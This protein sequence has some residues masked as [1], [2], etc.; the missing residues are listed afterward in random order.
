VERNFIVVAL[1]MVGVTGAAPTVSGQAV[2]AQ[3]APAPP[4]ERPAPVISPE[5]GADGRVTF[6]FRGPN[7][8][9]VAV[10][11]E[12]VKD[13]LT[14]QKDEQGVWS[15]TSEPLAPDYYGYS[16][17]V[18]GVTMFDSTN[19]SVIPNFL[20]RASEVHVPASAARGSGAASLPWEL[21]D[22]PHGEIH[23][24]FYKSGVVGDERGF[25]VYTPPGYDPRGKQTYPVLYLLHGYSDDANAWTA[26]GRA[27][28]ILDNLI[29]QGKA[30]PMLVVM[31]LGYGAPEVLAPHSGVFH[32]PAITQRNFDRFREA[33]LTEVI[34]RVEENYLVIKERNARA[35]AGLSMGGAETL[36]TGLNNLD[37][38]A[39]IA[40]L[41]SGG[42]TKDFD[43]EF[44][45]LDAKAN[46]QLR[47][48]WIACGTDDHLIGINRELR[49]WLAAKG[50]KHVDIE[51]PG[52]H[53]WMVWRRNL[54][55]FLPLL[56]R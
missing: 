37:K 23:H 44:P 41:S 9:E 26:V 43:K 22:V 49:A 40:P 11:I 13:S 35:I 4:A 47:L 32:D 34:P 3:K 45:G 8:K 24:H 30:K 1:L 46:E 15:A 50:V 42:I 18:D 10:E 53:T 5:V 6:R 48:L 20:Y 38:F 54:A 17:I 21:A 19:H 56:F 25:Y 7:V 51:T 27:N 29:A 52:G 55:E 2:A 31:P 14:M 28:V 36:L 16:F 39:W 12:S 33:L